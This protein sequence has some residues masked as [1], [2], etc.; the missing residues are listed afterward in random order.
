[1]YT[2]NTGHIICSNN[3]IFRKI[4]K[5]FS[6]SSKRFFEYN[7]DNSYIFIKSSKSNSTLYFQQD[8]EGAL[9]AYIRPLLNQAC[10]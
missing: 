10:L 2:S 1:M 3:Y 6:T 7:D 8:I 9:A 5:K 4:R